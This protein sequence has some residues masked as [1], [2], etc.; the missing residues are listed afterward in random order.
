MQLHVLP[1]DEIAVKPNRQ[2]REL[3]QTKILELAA[4]IGQNGLIHPI[5]VRSVN[6]EYTLVAGERRLKA[7]EHLWFLGSEVTYSGKV[8]PEGQVPCSFLGEIDPI[9][10]EEIELEENIRREDLNWKERADAVARLAALRTAQ[11]KRANLP[12]PSVAD[13]A[14]EVS[15]HREGDYQGDVRK[16]IIL[17]N[18]LK[19]PEAAAALDGATNRN[20]AFKRLKRHEEARRNAALGAAIGATFSAQMHSL[21]K[22]D[23]LQVMS[24]MPAE[25][26]DAICTDPPYGVGANDFSDSGGKVTGSHNY[27][28]S[29]EYWRKLA[30]ACASA[31]YRLAKA[32]SHAYIFCD[33]DRFGELRQLFTEV[34]FKVFRTPL[35]WYNP[36]AIRA[37]WPEHGPWRRY[38]CILFAIKGNRPVTRLYGDVLTYS[39]DSNLGWAAQKPVALISDLLNRTVRPGDTVLDAFAGSGSIFPAAHALK[40]KATGIE[41]D[42]VAYGIAAKR[43]KEL[44]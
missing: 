2:R 1:A 14:E 9:D 5:V 15:G 22:G 4:S 36:G 41:I 26:F 13:I 29:E 6:G 32:Q 34:G 31:F 11:A 20:D 44:E 18:A 10:A 27:D 8:I 21:Q 24:E 7:L 43:L 37:P 3:D 17:G 35:I 38:Q 16:D 39:P 23:C 28:D 25:A 33:I 19:D 30:T 42:E 40:C 12:A